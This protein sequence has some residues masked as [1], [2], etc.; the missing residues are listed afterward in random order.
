MVAVVTKSD[1]RGL[2]KPGIWASLNQSVGELLTL[3]YRGKPGPDIASRVISPNDSL[4]TAM[5]KLAGRDVYRLFVVDQS[6]KV[7]GKIT[8]T[9]LIRY[10]LAV[11]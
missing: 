9:R 4:E 11:R 8:L 2:V 1:I 3:R 6:M 7:I 10:V 5:A